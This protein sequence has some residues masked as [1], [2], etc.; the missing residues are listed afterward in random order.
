[1]GGCNAN[2][3]NLNMSELYLKYRPS[4]LDEIKGNDAT[5]RVLKSIFERDD[6]IPHA[7]I[8]EG[9]TGCGKT[10]IARIIANLLGC[11]IKSSDFVEVNCGTHGNKDIVR[12]IERQSKFMPFSEKCRIWLLDEAHMLGQGGAS[13]KNQA[14]NALLKILEDTPAHVYL[15]LCTT[16]P[17]RLIATIRNRCTTLSVAPLD[18]RDMKSLI[19]HVLKQEEVKDFPPDAIEAILDVVEGCPRKALK[20]LDQV[21]DLEDENLIASIQSSS[22]TLEGETSDLFNALVKNNSWKSI[23]GILNVLKRKGHPPEKIRRSI[24]GL[25]DYQITR[26]KNVSDAAKYHDIYVA[27][28]EPTYENGFPAITIACL[29]ALGG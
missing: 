18:D 12:E 24:T 27:F 14:Q 3:E 22:Q 9:S 5:V 7:W 1:M 19:T 23:S 8:L 11:D 25:C 17:Q 21:I 4:T 6:D 2:G 15:I 28:E 10:T 29:R 16:D 20:I 26:C 13:E